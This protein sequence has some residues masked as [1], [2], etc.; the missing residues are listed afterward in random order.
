MDNLTNEKGNI[1]KLAWDLGM[2]FVI[3]VLCVFLAIVLG[4]YVFP[5]LGRVF[6]FILGSFH[7]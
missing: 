3:V 1:K 2:A 5:L 4:P 6:D 7:M